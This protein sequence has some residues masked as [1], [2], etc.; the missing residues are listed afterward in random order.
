MRGTLTYLY[1]ANEFRMEIVGQFCGPCVAEAEAR[2]TKVLS[3]S[4]ASRVT[5]DISRL[6]GYENPGRTLLRRMH[7][8][9]ATIAAANPRSLIFLAEITTPKRLGPTPSLIPPSLMRKSPAAEE[10]E[11]ERVPKVKRAGA[12]GG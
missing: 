11:L 3:E 8:H 2:W 9:G 6:A 5:I 12:G 10:N 4:S 1:E 7:Q